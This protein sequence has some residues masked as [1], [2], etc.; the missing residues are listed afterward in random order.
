[1]STDAPRTLQEFVVANHADGESLPKLRS[2]TLA[3]DS[4]W[5]FSYSCLYRFRVLGGDEPS[6]NV[7]EVSYENDFVD[8]HDEIEKDEEYDEVDVE[9]ND[10][11]F[12]TDAE[13]DR[14]A[15]PEEIE[16]ERDE[17][18]GQVDE[19]SEEVEEM[20]KTSEPQG[21][22]DIESTLE[23]DENDN[24]DH[25]AVIDEQ[26]SVEEGSD[27][28]M[29]HEE[30]T[31]DQDEASSASSDE[32]DQDYDPDYHE[33]VAVDGA[34]TDDTG[35]EGTEHGD[36][37]HNSEYSVTQGEGIEAPDSDETSNVPEKPDATNVQHNE[38]ED[39][40][41]SSS[42][43]DEDYPSDERTEDD[44]ERRHID[45][46]HENEA[47]HRWDSTDQDDHEEEDSSD[48]EEGDSEDEDSGDPN[49]RVEY[50]DGIRYEYHI[51]D[52]ESGDDSGDSR[53]D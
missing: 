19:D 25:V 7:I 29:V 9:S 46:V 41:D 26:E 34:A 50:H 38:E 36:P 8:E 17:L 11:D 4:N 10:E 42:V 14:Y 5:G 2:I 1:M 31:N 35:G 16:E 6:A 39:A 24:Q 20:V 15:V 53:D 45:D 21:V 13:Y 51:K 43:S 33:D 28:A 40:S 27:G 3:I 52:E 22:A 44:A 48:D 49:V 47:E 18:E 37:P 12:D 23:P 30:A 32:E